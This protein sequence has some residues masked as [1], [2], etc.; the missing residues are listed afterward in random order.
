MAQVCRLYVTAYTSRTALTACLQVGRNLSNQAYFTFHVLK[1]KSASGVISFHAFTSRILSFDFRAQEVINVEKERVNRAYSF[2]ELLD[3]T[4]GCTIE[5]KEDALHVSIRLTKNRE[6]TCVAQSPLDAEK[7][8]RLVTGIRSYINNGRPLD[9]FTESIGKEFFPGADRTVLHVG[10]VLKLD[11]SDSELHSMGPR[12]LVLVPGKL[13]VFGGKIGSNS[14]TAFPRNVMAI[15]GAGVSLYHDGLTMLFKFGKDRHDKFVFT[16]EEPKHRDAW[17]AALRLSAK[18]LASKHGHEASHSKAIDPAGARRGRA[19]TVGL[20]E[21]ASASGDV[22]LQMP[23]SPVVP[24][25]LRAKHSIPEDGTVEG[26]A[27]PVD[28]EEPEDGADNACAM[29][30]GDEHEHGSDDHHTK[31]CVRSCTRHVNALFAPTGR[32]ASPHCTL[33]HAAA[34]C[35][36][37]MLQC[38]GASRWRIV[39]PGGGGCELHTTGAV[40]RRGGSAARKRPAGRAGSS[41]C[42]RRGIGELWACAHTQCIRRAERRASPWPNCIAGAPR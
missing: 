27:D 14:Y 1:Y 20:L 42:N 36:S 9:K 11:P 30:Y 15:D 32:T 38:A 7:L 21:E 33:C 28:A 4:Q 6:Y 25:A 26:E 39:S 16:C 3:A 10:H 8:V 29:D 17:H 12:F 23:P 22:P 19:A 40:A 18:M 35:M 34:L 31:V 24:D 41:A 5:K 2:D 37:S 13:F